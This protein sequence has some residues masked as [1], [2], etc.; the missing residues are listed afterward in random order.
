MACEV[1]VAGNN[2][3]DRISL[4]EII[5][6]VACIS[7]DAGEAVVGGAEVEEALVAVVEEDAV[8]DSVMQPD[9]ER[10]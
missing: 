2:L 8:L 6:H 4:D 3:R 1:S 9:E 5:I 10:R 7:G